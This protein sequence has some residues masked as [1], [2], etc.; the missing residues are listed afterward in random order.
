MAGLVLDIHFG[1]LARWMIIFWRKAV[2]RKWPTV[3]GTIVRCHFEKHGYGGDYVV[4]Q[5]EYKAEFERF[6]GVMKKP[7]IYPNY[8]EAFVRHHAPDS[9]LRIRVSP[10]D[11]TRSFL[12]LD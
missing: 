12:V 4:L 10:K 11:S 1:F 2:S 9:E 7:Y 5:Y 6:H 3:A 8:A